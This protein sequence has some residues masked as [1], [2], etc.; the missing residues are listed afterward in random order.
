MNSGH[1]LRKH[2]TEIR[3]KYTTCNRLYFLS[4]FF[5]VVQD[6]LLE[7]RCQDLVDLLFQFETPP[8]SFDEI[9]PKFDEAASRLSKM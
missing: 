9:L 2:K 4:Y 3:T 5:V 6:E 1:Y 8:C 7:R